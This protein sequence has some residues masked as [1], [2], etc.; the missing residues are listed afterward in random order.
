MGDLVGRVTIE[1]DGR[2]VLST[3]VKDS[4]GKEIK[5]VRKIEFKHEV[6]L[7][8]R[9]NLELVEADIRASAPGI[10]LVGDPKTGCMRQVKEIVWD[11]EEGGSFKP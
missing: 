11:D 4:T 8:P 2:S 9:I 5:G 6:G 7:L 3:S 10:F 1:C